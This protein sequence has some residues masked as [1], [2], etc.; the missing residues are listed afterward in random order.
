MAGN[1][2]TGRRK[3]GLAKIQSGAVSGVEAFAVELE[4]NVSSFGEVAMVV[5]GLPDAAVREST[6]RVSTALDNNGFSR[7]VGRTTINL[8]PADIR[9]EGPLFDLPMAIGVI[10]ASGKLAATEGLEATAMVGE[11]ALSGDVRRVRGVLPIAL[12]MRRMGIRRLLVPAENAAE[13]AVV[14]GLE[15][16]AVTNLREAI[17]V[18]EGTTAATPV[19]VDRE[20]WEQESDE[21]ALDY[22][23][24]KG[25]EAAKRAITIAVAGGHNLL[26]I[27]PPGTGKSMLAKRI[28]SILPPMTLEEALE[29]TKIHS[30]AGLL[31]P[32]RPLLRQRPFRSPHHTVSD[33]GLL[34][35]GSHPAPGEV[36]LAHHGVLFLDELPEFQRS[37]LEVLRQPLEDGIVTI[38]RAAASATFPCQIILVAA[39]NPCPC[40]FLGD[41]KR[42]CRCSRL[43]VQGYRNRVSGPLLDRIDLHIE[44]PAT[45]FQAL[46]NMKSGMSSAA[47][48]EQVM[49]ARERQAARFRGHRT[50]RHNGAMGRREIEA[51]CRLDDEAVGTLHVAMSDMHFSA[52][53]HDRIIKVSR[54]IAD[55]DGADAITATHIHEALQYRTLDRNFWL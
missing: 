37:A 52:R 29:T 15:V 41:P 10:A 14:E 18:V 23:D 46:Q 40:G 33:I 27:G 21:D 22:S 32:N 25:Q 45:R 47:M 7:F 36:S 49:A 2:V 8:A 48:R 50:I 34:G 53:A 6:F 30:I 35:G 39:M 42:E 1:N 54:T 9:K 26:M 31:P 17:G 43:Q 12:E 19:V 28:G 3:M 11:L 4:V 55:I 44:V 16:Y 5:V 13:A 38:T 20:A 51:Y 24:V